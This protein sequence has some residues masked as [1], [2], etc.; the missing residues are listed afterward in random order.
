MA[1]GRVT[2]EV[3]VRDSLSDPD[4]GSTSRVRNLWQIQAC[5]GVRVNRY[6]EVRVSVMTAKKSL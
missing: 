2:C 6:V 5:S 4:G 1:E 3:G